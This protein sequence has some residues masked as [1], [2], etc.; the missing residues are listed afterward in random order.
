VHEDHAKVRQL[1]LLEEQTAYEDRIIPT[2]SRKLEAAFIA[3]LI[4]PRMPPKEEFDR[5]VADKMIEVINSQ[6]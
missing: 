3:G 1:R 2:S 6:R 4:G 5:I